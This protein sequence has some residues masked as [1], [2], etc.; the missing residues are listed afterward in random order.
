MSIII[1]DNFQ[2]EP[3]ATPT[4][5]PPAGKYFV[6]LK[7]DGL[8][9]RKDSTGSENVIATPIPILTIDPV[10]P[11]VGQSWI[12]NSIIPSGSMVGLLGV[13]YPTARTDLFKFRTYTSFGVKEIVYT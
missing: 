5:N 1:E 12:Y 2:L 7:S 11:F 9:Y 13:T 4:G 10:L 8:W 3:N 6:Y